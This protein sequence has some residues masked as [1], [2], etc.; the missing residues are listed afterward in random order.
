VQL[1][2][3]DKSVEVVGRPGVLGTEEAL[4]RVLETLPPL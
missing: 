1:V 2:E 3:S 4:R